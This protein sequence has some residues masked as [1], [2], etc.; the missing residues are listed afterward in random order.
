MNRFH[1]QYTRKTKS[2]RKDEYHLP[3]ANR[4]HIV[5]ELYR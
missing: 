3:N 4:Y 1:H 5:C 2:I